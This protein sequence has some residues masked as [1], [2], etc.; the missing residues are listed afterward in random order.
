MTLPLS[1]WLMVQP[2]ALMMFWPMDDRAYS[3]TTGSGDDTFIVT[4]DGDAVDAGGVDP[5]SFAIST[6][7]GD[8]AVDII[9]VAGVSQQT[10]FI[11]DNLSIETGDGA[12]RV[13]INGYERFNIETGAGDDYVEI[14]SVDPADGSTGAWTFGATTG[15]Q[16][17]VDRVLYKAELTVNFAGFESTVTVDTDAAGNFVADQETINAA[18]IAAIDASPVLTELLDYDL[19][20][21]DQYPG[22][23]FPTL[24][25]PTNCPSTCSSRRWWMPMPATVKLSSPDGNL[26]AIRQGIIDTTVLTSADLEN[27][28]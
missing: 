24:T 14:T 3:Y 23:H 12:D 26:T 2:P 9:S 21:S 11:L 4:L 16:P 28:G 20:T 5:E 8:D 18:I 27:A 1:V 10:M 17:F 22:H 15:V 25:A 7:S 6:G 19:G 13:T